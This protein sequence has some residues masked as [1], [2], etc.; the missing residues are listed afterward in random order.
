[1]TLSVRRV[2]QLK[3]AVGVETVSTGVSAAA[4]LERCR[5]QGVSMLVVVDE[6]GDPVG[7]VH[8]ADLMGEQGPADRS[9][10]VDAVMRRDFP[11][12]SLEDSTHD[13][14]ARLTAPERG[15]LPVIAADTLVGVVSRGDVRRA[16]RRHRR[17]MAAADGVRMR[18]SA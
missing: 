13:V 9:A 18:P 5:R 12:C 16:A 2:L 14:M 3:G 10:A 15:V 8:E 7:V 4:A 1:M 11:T 6:I 17:V